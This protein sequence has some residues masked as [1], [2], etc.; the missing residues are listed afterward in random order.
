[1][2]RDL[3]KTIF[4]PSPA[5]QAFKKCMAASRELGTT[6][7]MFHESMKM[8][9]TELQPDESALDELGRIL[10]ASA[11]PE[12]T[13]D[14]LSVF[15]GCIVTERLGGRWQ[16]ASGSYQIADVGAKKVTLD[17]VGDIRTPLTG[18]ERHSPRAV[19]ERIRERVR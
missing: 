12:Q 3:F 14:G 8:V 13:L 5:D 19:Y 2:I 7:M 11:E 9:G 4:R 6:A 17:L 10:A 18:Q 16:R 1:M 15:L